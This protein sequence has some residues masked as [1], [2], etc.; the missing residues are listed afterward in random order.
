MVRLATWYMTDCEQVLS[1]GE[2]ETQ[3]VELFFDNTR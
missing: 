1:S 2:K 3:G